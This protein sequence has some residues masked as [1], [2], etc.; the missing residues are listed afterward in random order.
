MGKYIDM[1]TKSNKTLT[2][3]NE[4]LKVENQSLRDEIRALAIENQR[5]SEQVCQH[6]QQCAVLGPFVANFFPVLR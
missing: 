6:R 1:I 2:A 3:K 5:L 4:C